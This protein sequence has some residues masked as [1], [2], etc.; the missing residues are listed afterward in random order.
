MRRIFWSRKNSFIILDVTSSQDVK[1]I[2][3]SLKRH[4]QFWE[5]DLGAN[6]FILE[7]IKHGYN[8]PFG[9]S[10]TKFHSK[11]NNLSSLRNKQ[12]V[13]ETIQD[14]LKNKFIMESKEAPFCVNP[15]TVA[16]NKDKLRLVLDL[17]HV[18]EFLEFP[19]FKYEG[20]NEVSEMM[21]RDFIFVN[22]TSNRVIFI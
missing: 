14:L 8:L 19:S 1:K 15:L 21:D 17:G 22:L 11:R 18:N 3:N 12:F 13:E 6:K 16:G 9:S 20:L 7:T 2:T 4:V 10:P 5:K